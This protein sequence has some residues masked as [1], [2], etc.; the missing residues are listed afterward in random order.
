MTFPRSVGQVPIHYNHLNTGGRS[1]TSDK[2]GRA[3]TLISLPRRLIRSVFGLSYTKFS[4]SK[5]S[6]SKPVYE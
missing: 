2:C 3:D 4:Y 6:M 1:K 5:I